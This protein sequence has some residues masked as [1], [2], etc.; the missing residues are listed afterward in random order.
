LIATEFV[1]I[2]NKQKIEEI[3]N[4]YD[5][6]IDILYDTLDIEENII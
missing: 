3:I 5:H 4:N 1:S 2:T 6:K